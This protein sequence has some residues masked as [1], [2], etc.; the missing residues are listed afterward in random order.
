MHIFQNDV[1]S[2]KT[3]AGLCEIALVGWDERG[4]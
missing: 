2:Q 1:Q 3:A 4:I